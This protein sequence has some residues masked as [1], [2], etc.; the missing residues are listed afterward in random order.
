MAMH[1]YLALLRTTIL[2]DC[3]IQVSV[4]LVLPKASYD[5]FIFII[6]DLKHFHSIFMKAMLFLTVFGAL[7][8]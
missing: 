4:S 7:Y 3:I 6:T 5:R 8:S 1:Q 2:V